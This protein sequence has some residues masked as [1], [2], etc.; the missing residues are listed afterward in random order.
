M[1]DSLSM[2]DAGAIAAL[3]FNDGGAASTR[4]G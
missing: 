2:L 1:R 3:T 4:A